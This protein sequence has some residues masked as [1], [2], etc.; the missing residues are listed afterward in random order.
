MRQTI[1]RSGVK[2]WRTVLA[3][4]FVVAICTVSARAQNLFSNLQSASVLKPKQV[5]VT[6]DF[7][8]VSLSITGES[9]H[10]WDIYGLQLG[11]GVFR[12]VEFRARY[13]YLNWAGFGPNVSFINFGPKIGLWKDFLALYVP[14]EFGFGDMVD[15]SETWSVHPTLMGTIPVGKTVEINPA[16]K[17]LIPFQKDSQTLVALDLGLGI[18]LLESKNLAIRPEGGI[19]FHPGDSGSFLELSVGVSY[20]FGK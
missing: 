8:T 6:P 7:S 13:G 14:F 11:I 10:V 4:I 20:R 15:V 2:G 9:G 3:L 16:V 17:A 1:K 18:L 5:E 19:L 12:G